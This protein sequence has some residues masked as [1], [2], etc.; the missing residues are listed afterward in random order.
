MPTN[1]PVEWIH[2]VL[3]MFVAAG[4]VWMW[5][6]KVVRDHAIREALQ[7]KRIEDIEKRLG[8]GDDAL[9]A[10]RKSLAGIESTLARMDQRLRHIEQNGGTNG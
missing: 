1:D 10:I 3:S 4:T 5:L 8:R 9:A 6:S 2:V 7:E